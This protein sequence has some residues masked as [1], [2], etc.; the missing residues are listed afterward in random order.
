MVPIPGAPGGAGALRALN[1]PAP[2]GVRSDKDGKPLAVRLERAWRR[3]AQVSDRWRLGP[4]E[5]WTGQTVD[6]LYFTLRLDDGQRCTIFQD[7]LTSK[8]YSQ[9]A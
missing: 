5:W 9:R 8:W 7:L 4:D 1:A 3:V 6:R 2:V